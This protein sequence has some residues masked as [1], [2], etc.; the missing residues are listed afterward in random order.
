MIVFV[1]A[2]NLVLTARV[3]MCEELTGCSFGI[4]K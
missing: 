4:W 2:I 3:L 1:K